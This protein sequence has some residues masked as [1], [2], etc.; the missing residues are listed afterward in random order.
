MD[1]IEQQIPTRSRRDNSHLTP[2]LAV[3]NNVPFAIPFNVR[4]EMFRQFVR[5]DMAKH[6]RA[7]FSFHSRT[8]AVIR[9][10]HVSEDGFNKLGAVDLK[11]RVQITFVDHFGEEE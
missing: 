5:M 8:R 11:G 7:E 6:D 9:R 4:V 3:L 1:P 2:R 10:D